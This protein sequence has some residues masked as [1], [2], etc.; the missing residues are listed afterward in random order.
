MLHIVNHPD[1]EFRHC[2][3]K[4]TQQR[5]AVAPE[6]GSVETL[7][8]TM[9]FRKGDPIVESPDGNTYYCLTEE[10]FAAAYDVPETT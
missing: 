5:F 1:L 8:G 3:H 6:D 10:A 2:I 4:P 7:H 9:T